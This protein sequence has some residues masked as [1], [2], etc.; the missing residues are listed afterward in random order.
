MPSWEAW[1]W[2]R[3]AELSSATWAERSELSRWSAVARLIEWLIPEFSFSSATCIATI[4]ISAK[5]ISPIHAR[6]RIRRSSSELST[7]R[8]TCWLN[9]AG[10]AGR[11]IGRRSGSAGWA[12]PAGLAGPDT[13]RGPT[14][15][16]AGVPV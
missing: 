13:R 2:I 4:P 1:T 8:A 14:G 7:T 15:R 12:G 5:A 3:A 10:E 11:A 16:R 9:G 6:P